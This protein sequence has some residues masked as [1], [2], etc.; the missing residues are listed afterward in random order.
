LRALLAE[1]GAQAI[2][3]TRAEN[4]AWLTGG[5]DVLVNREGPPIAE[6][7]VTPEVVAVLTNQIEAERLRAEEL[8]GGI[9]LAVYDWFEPAQRARRLGELTGGASVLSDSDIDLSEVR[10]PLLP[11]EIGR[12]RALGEAAS[13]AMTEVAMTLAPELSE[14]QVAAR[15]HGALRGRGLQ[16]PVVLVAGQERFGRYRHPV[17]QDVPFGRAGLLVI[18]AQQRGL[19]VSLSRMV[20]FGAVPEANRERL[21]RVQQ[22]EAAM[23]E[24]TRPGATLAEVFAAAQRAYAEVGFPDAWREHHQGGPTGYQ[25]RDVLATPDECRAV[26][27]GVAYAWNPSLP[28]AKAEDTFLC[29]EGGLENL[30]FD[31][32]WPTVTVAGR[33]RADILL[34]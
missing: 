17:P 24:A 4:L 19:V 33:A 15:L 14:R 6:A 2:V 13:Q 10:N 30:T 28:H 5:S 27:A 11:V 1:Q 9:A 32:R 29:G 22:V 25:T 7:L 26:R 18:C 34:L 3:L 20:A 12:Y 8:P 31:A 16:V 23:L 21:A